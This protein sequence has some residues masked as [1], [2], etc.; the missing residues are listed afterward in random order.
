MNLFG[1]LQT[2]F[3]ALKAFFGWRE[4]LSENKPVDEVIGD[5]K[6]LEKA[7]IYAEKAISLVYKHAKFTSKFSK[8]LFNAS[9]QKFRKLR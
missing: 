2:L 7:C 8:L 1:S 4:T 3:E 6:D 9:V 5:K